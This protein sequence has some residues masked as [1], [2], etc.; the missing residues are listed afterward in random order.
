MLYSIV[1]PVYNSS[2][3]IHELYHR[4]QQV[5]ENVIREDFELI[6]VDD[7]SR[8]GSLAEIKKISETDQR[9]K[10]ILLAKNHG[11]Q[12]AVMCGIEHSSGDYVITM[13]DDLQHP[14]EEIPKLIAKI[15]S[16]PGLDVV[17]GMYDSKKHSGIRKLGTRLLD[18]LSNIVFKKAKDLKLTSFRIMKSFVADNLSEV[19][20]KSPTVGHC[21]LMVDGNIAN[22][23]VRHEPRKVGK[24]GYSLLGLVKTFMGNVYVNSDLPLRIVGHIGTI[25]ALGSLILGIYYLIRYLTGHVGVS[26]WTTLVMIVLFMNGLLLFSVGIIGRYLMVNIN[27]AKRL[28]KY[29]IKEKNVDQTRGKK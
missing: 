15:Q 9:V 4:I 21:L 22:T 6:L 24:S 20:L 10:Y 12:K 27:E 28:P 2:G 5:F 16:D 23:E 7:A 11:Q 19:N 13:D 14:P 26:G 3:M 25:S 8:D 18:A 29:S 17:I 1:I